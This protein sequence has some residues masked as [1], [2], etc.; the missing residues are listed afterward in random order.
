MSDMHITDPDKQPKTIRGAKPDPLDDFW[1]TAAKDSVKGSVS[2]LEDAAKQLVT[3][4]SLAQTIYFAAIS[5]SDLKKSQVTSSSDTVVTAAVLFLIPVILWTISLWLAVCVFKPRIYP[6]NLESPDD[7][8]DAV[9][10]MVDYKHKALQRAHAF[11]TAG[12][13][14]LIVDIFIYLAAIPAPP[15]G[16]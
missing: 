1:L 14:A 3:I 8:R 13:V 9:N 11:L 12:F 16:K 10:A 7:A 2:A 15:A 5:F 4:T 6:V